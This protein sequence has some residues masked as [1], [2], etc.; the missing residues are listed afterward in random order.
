MP[1]ETDDDSNGN[2]SVGEC[3]NK[4]GDAQLLRFLSLMQHAIASAA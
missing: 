3:C 1:T 4:H 2:V